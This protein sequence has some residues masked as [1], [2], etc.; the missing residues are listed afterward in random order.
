MMLA[1]FGDSWGCGSWS[2]PTQVYGYGDGYLTEKFGQYFIDVSNH[3][4][5]GASNLDSISL[6]E[7]FLKEHTDLSNVKILIIQTDPMR[8]FFS[9]ND[10][11]NIECPFKNFNLRNLLDFNIELF[12]HKLDRLGKQYNKTI[13][14]IG[15]CSDVSLEYK[16]YSHI[17][18]P[19]ESWI[20]LLDSSHQPSIYYNTFDI[21]TII[22]DFTK[23]NRHVLDLLFSKIKLIEKNRNDAFGYRLDTHPSHR[24][25]DILVENIYNKLI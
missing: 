19:C 21:S 20:K 11:H 10:Q 12:Y 14:L 5:G 25:I 7:D 3:S 6:L 13:N 16:K 22:E 15:G 18:S 4:R 9:A 23:D 1:I 2:D 24:S 17:H 8:N